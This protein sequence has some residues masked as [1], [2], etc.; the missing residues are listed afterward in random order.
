[1]M[2]KLRERFLELRVPT[3]HTGYT[4]RQ[5]KSTKVSSTTSDQKARKIWEASHEGRTLVAQGTLY[6]EDGMSGIWDALNRQ[7]GCR[8]APDHQIP[9]WTIQAWEQ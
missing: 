6:N 9:P 5:S 3:E 4:M 2:G 7:I 8:T 1:M